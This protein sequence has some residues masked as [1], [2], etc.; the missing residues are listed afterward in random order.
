MYD[1]NISVIISNAFVRLNTEAHKIGFFFGKQINN[2]IQHAYGTDKPEEAFMNPSA[3]PILLLPWFA[4][5]SLHA[6]PIG[7][8]QSDLIYSTINGYSYIRLIDNVMD[9]HGK[10]EVT[11]LPVLNF[12]HTKFQSQYLKYFRHNHSFWDYFNAV[13]FHSAEVTLRDTQL[14]EIDKDL[15]VEVS[16]QK[17]CAAK[18]PIAAVFY[19]YDC[20]ECV[21]DWERFL[22]LFGCWHQMWNDIF[23]WVK[24]TR[25][26]TQ[27]YFLSEANRSKRPGEPVIDW[28]IREGF[29]WGLEVLELWMDELE[30]VA[31]DLNSSLL[32]GYLDDRRRT[33]SGQKA[34][35]LHGLK[36][37]ENLLDGLKNAFDGFD[38]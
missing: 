15:F 22:D 37:M 20:P 32:V 21:E 19:H 28:V 11:F 17:T 9:G 16:A 5:T 35:A 38:G 13:W 24:D 30:L 34:E 1:P 10:Q 6:E 25:Y 8:F 14:E 29:N 18:I 3:F 27:T 33:L 7:A 36:Q 26:E 31:G 2:W 12:F 23:S 4:E